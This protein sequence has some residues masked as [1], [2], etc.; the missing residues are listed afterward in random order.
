[1]VAPTH[2]AHSQFPAPAAAARRGE[3]ARRAA[4]RGAVARGPVARGAVARA[5]VAGGGQPP[6]RLTA[7][8]RRVVAGA[9]W[10]AAFVGLVAAAVVVVVLVS[11]MLAP[12]A[13]AGDWSAG[14]DTVAGPRPVEVVVAPGDTLWA[15]AAR[16]APDRDPR[17]FVAEVYRIND[18]PE[19]G[20]VLV[21][22]RLQLPVG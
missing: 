5:A 17:D 14:A 15:L 6:L 3:P 21:G 2:L 12:G 16:H 7:R 19:S 9:R 22:Q 18:L 13:V 4:A 20:L 8:G 1:M 10:A 11:S